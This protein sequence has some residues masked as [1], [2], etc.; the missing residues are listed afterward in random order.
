MS[1]IAII[2]A[3][4]ESSRFPGKPLQPI[5]G[6]PMLGHVY[7]RTVMSTLLD[8]VAIAT[9]NHEIAEYAASIGARVVM[10][11]ATHERASDRTAEA[12]ETLERECGLHPDIVVMVQGDEPMVT[13]AMIDAAVRPM[14]ADASIEVV[15][16][17]APLR[18]ASEHDDRNEPKV[19][20]DLAGNALYFSREAIPSRWKEGER[21]S[22]RKQV[23]IIPFRR[24]FLDAFTQLAPTPLEIAESIDMLRVL[25]H[26]HRVRMVPS[27][28]PDTYSVDTPEDLAYVERCMRSD[29]LLVQYRAVAQR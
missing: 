12:V 13:P 17:M 1:T 15:N 5:L 2:P 29:P 27:P 14:L 23:C 25:E 24:N 11:K 22:M 7:H 9:C 26:G 20:T 3:R 16:L 19:V 6:M 8:A 10:T 28:T 4:M 18:D 21:V